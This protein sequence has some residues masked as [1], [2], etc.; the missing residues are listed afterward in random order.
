MAEEQ[1]C[2]A[3]E[4]HRLCANNCG[5]FGSPATQ[6]LCSKCY[7][8]LRLD[9]EQASS[10]KFAVEK[11]LAAAA[12]SSSSSP[13]SASSVSAFPATDAPLSPPALTLSAAETTIDRWAPLTI[14]AAASVTSVLELPATQTTMVSQ[15][16]R[17][18]TCRKRVGLT[19]FKCRC[20]TTFCG[21][22]RYPEQHGCTFDFKALGKEAIAK[23][24][25]VVKAEKLEK[26]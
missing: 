12:S 11:S 25:P 1:R 24:N 9:E 13:S 3:S 2:E 10:A 4:G 23:A 5:F 18:A 17:C 26:I 8:D 21:A 19:G 7:R 20:G 16:N 14:S 6:N 22:H 15:P